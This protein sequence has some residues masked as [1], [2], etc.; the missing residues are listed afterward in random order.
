MK[1]SEFAR[2]MRLIYDAREDEILCSEF[3]DLVSQYVDR[4]I[5]GEPV[6]DQMPQVK[7]H[8]EHCRVCGEEYTA[9]RDLARMEAEG[10]AP[11]SGEAEGPSQ[12]S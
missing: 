7:Y 2:K 11:L 8:L 4:E 9:L 12:G 3:F 10:R 5:A 1:Q 6:A